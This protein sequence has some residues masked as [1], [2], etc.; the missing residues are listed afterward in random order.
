MNWLDILYAFLSLLGGIGVFLYGMKLMGDS[1]EMVAGNEIKRMFA[2]ISDNKIIGVGIGAVTTAV[3]QSSAAVTVM[4]IGFVNSGLMSLIQAAAIVFGANIGTTSTALIVALG[5]GGLADVKLTV[6]FAALAGVGAMTIMFSKK[7]KIKKIGGIITGLGMIFVGLSVMT[8]SMTIFSESP[9]IVEF[10]AKISN[11]A[12]LLLF[13]IAFTALIQ[14]SSAVSGIVV[15]MSVAGLLSFDQGLYII[16][17]SNIGTCITSLIASIGTN[18]NAKRTAVI[19]LMFNVIGVLIFGLVSISGVFSKM[20]MPINNPAMRIALLHTFFNVV[21]TIILLPFMNLLVKLVSKMVP[22]KHK[23][24]KTDEPHLYYLE[25]RL[26]RTPPVAVAQ[27]KNEVINMAEIAKTNFDVCVDAVM[28]AKVSD[29]IED[30]QRN[31]NTLNFLNREMAKY[32]VKL[33]QVDLSEEDKQLIG[34][35]YH[36]ISDIERIGDYAENISEYAE[37]LEND[38]VAFSEGAIKEIGT[39]KDTIN[40]LYNFVMKT[41]KEATIDYI[42][43]VNYYEE[44]V[45]KLKEE[46]SEHHIERMNNGT[47]TPEV[48]AL[49]LSLASNAERVADHM[50]NIAF[51]VKSYAKKNEK[52]EKEVKEA[53]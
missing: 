40:N 42:A 30:V 9:K 13:G 20:F 41:Y 48:G 44:S 6:I 4:A 7:D 22:E 27:M 18:T 16:L 50:T 46:M 12:L 15:T 2:K 28:R 10:L 3:V 8:D 14:S 24:E 21:T 37:K 19:H 34:T 1:L 52:K 53:K 47:C 33:S 45:D 51:A 43:D 23:D 11:P 25:E 32:L 39:L 17:G 35:T 49:Y 5:V 38:G 36:T 31:E 29:V 26:L